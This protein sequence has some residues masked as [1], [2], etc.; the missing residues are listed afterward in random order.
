MNQK[1]NYIF[2]WHD[3]EHSV[4][5]P[6]HI[7]SLRTFRNFNDIFLD[8]L[9]PLRWAVKVYPSVLFYDVCVH[10]SGIRSL[11]LVFLLLLLLPQ[12]FPSCPLYTYIFTEYQVQESE[13][14]KT[15]LRYFFLRHFHPKSRDLRHIS[16]VILARTMRLLA[17]C[18]W[19]RQALLLLHH[20]TWRGC[21]DAPSFFHIFFFFSFNFLFFFFLF[22]FFSTPRPFVYKGTPIGGHENIHTHTHTHTYWYM[23]FIW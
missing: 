19:Y 20:L 4:H 13:R 12:A 23:S 7:F 16:N 2:R 1:K 3:Y 22:S 6:S 21:K 11:L 8:P 15:M 18:L 17:K 9:H 14:D 5:H 10:A